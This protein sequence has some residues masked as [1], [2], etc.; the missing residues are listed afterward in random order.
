VV[1]G[2]PE[3]VTTM[4]VFVA[5]KPHVPGKVVHVSHNVYHAQIT[6]NAKVQTL[7][8]TYSQ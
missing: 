3:P 5:L 4:A 6:V 8:I 1:D 2:V 7:A